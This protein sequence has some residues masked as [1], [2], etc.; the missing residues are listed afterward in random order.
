MKSP[1]SPLNVGSK[2]YKVIARFY[3]LAFFDKISSTFSIL[4]GYMAGLKS[5]SNTQDSFLKHNIIWPNFSRAT[6]LA[7]I[8]ISNLCRI[9]DVCKTKVNLVEN[10]HLILEVRIN[11]II[12]M[13]SSVFLCGPVLCRRSYYN[14]RYGGKS[15]ISEYYERC[16]SKFKIESKILRQ[17]VYAPYYAIVSTFIG[18]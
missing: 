1:Q 3:Y 12:R 4:W 8:C 11:L 14:T 16:V 17:N 5:L 13:S 15:W 6:A 7:L 18:N 10:V 2:P 9:V